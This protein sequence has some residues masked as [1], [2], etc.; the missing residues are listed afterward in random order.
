[1]KLFLLHVA[2]LF[3]IVIHHFF[4][5]LEPGDLRHDKSSADPPGQFPDAQKLDA[6]YITDPLH[7][8]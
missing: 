5:V 7:L 4:R 6:F 3:H 2:H 1:M 8:F